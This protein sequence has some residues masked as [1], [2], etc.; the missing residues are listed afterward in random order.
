V[1]PV[2]LD[3]PVGGPGAVQWDGTYLAVATNDNRN[4]LNKAGI[5]RVPVSG[6]T[7]KVVDVLRPRDF[8]HALFVLHGRAVIGLGQQVRRTHLGVAVSG[9]READAV[10]S[11]MRQGQR[12]GDFALAHRGLMPRDLEQRLETVRRTRRC[13]TAHRARR[14]RGEPLLCRSAS[15]SRGLP[16]R[17]RRKRSTFHA[18]RRCRPPRR[19]HHLL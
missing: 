5:Y 3:K 11:S 7:G 15:S 1:T 19:A 2:T 4:G 8:Y 13:R 18:K 17:W 14:H 10:A 16:W 9:G 6:N 12:N